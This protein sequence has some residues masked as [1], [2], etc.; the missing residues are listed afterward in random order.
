MLYLAT[1]EKPNNLPKID[2]LEVIIELKQTKGFV[3]EK[4]EE[5]QR[6]KWCEFTLLCGRGEYV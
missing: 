1:P 4:C 6:C 3:A 2:T 5:L